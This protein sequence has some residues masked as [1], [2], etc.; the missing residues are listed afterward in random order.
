[1]ATL[2]Q[3]HQQWATRPD[4]ERFVSLEDMA[5]FT[6]RQRRISNMG[7]TPNKQLLVAPVEDDPSAIAVEMDNGV[8]APSNWAFTQMCQLVGAPASYMRTLPS[9]LVSDCLNQ[10]MANRKVEQVGWLTRNETEGSS[11]SAVTGP[12]YGRIWNADVVDA[13][14]RYFGTGSSAQ[15]TIPGEFGKEVP[16]TKQNTTLYAG[17]RDMFI[18]LADEKNRIEMPN[19]RNGQVGSLARGFFIQ[20]SEVG[21]STLKIGTFLFDYVCSNRMVWGAEGFKEVSIRHSLN[22]PNRWVSEIMPA[23]ESMQ[24]AS[25][26]NIENAVKNAQAR[27]LDEDQVEKILVKRFTKNQAKAIKLAHFNDE[28]KPIESTWDL[29]TG[30]TAYARGYKHQDQRVQLEREAG[31]ILATYN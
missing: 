4:D 16:I 29:V 1:M 21:S 5:A 18:F 28:D 27:R 14:M 3:A 23:L 30:I 25:M 10:S 22:A 15:F 6:A 12:T 8:T 11:L 31:K 26:F 9:D 19:R 24:T 20:N 13:V 7:T 2:T 17:D